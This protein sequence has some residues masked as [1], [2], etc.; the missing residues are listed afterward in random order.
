MTQRDITDGVLPWS[1]SGL[2]EI[3]NLISRA[4]ALH[5]KKALRCKCGSHKSKVAH[6]VSLPSYYT[7]QMDGKTTL[8]QRH[9]YSAQTHVQQVIR[10][11]SSVPYHSMLSFPGLDNNCFSLQLDEVRVNLNRAA[12]CFGPCCE[13][14]WMSCLLALFVW[15]V[16]SH[17]VWMMAAVRVP[18]ASVILTMAARSHVEYNASCSGWVALQWARPIVAEV[19]T[20]LARMMLNAARGEHNPDCTSPKTSSWCIWMLEIVTALVQLWQVRLSFCGR[21]KCRLPPRKL[22]NWWG[23]FCDHGSF[24][25]WSSKLSLWWSLL[26]GQRLRWTQQQQQQQ[27]WLQQWW[28][29]LSRTWFKLHY[30]K[31]KWSGGLLGSSTFSLD[32]HSWL[33]LWL[34]R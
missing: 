4:D 14:L 13:S 27:V 8:I 12:I 2:Q 15:P 6:W 24:D 28:M 16:G 23:W 30:F 21:R 9:C 5:Q 17:L 33:L 20:S 3:A 22:A 1:T 29:R 7:T 11:I 25:C 32:T 26:V 19:S 10:S 34:Q 18:L 31:H